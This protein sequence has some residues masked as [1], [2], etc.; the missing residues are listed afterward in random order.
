M[1][2]SRFA[3]RFCLAKPV[4]LPVCLFAIAWALLTC[5]SSAKAADD[6]FQMWVPVQIVHPFGEEWAASMQAEVRLKD[7]ISE[8][9]E[10]VLK[11][12]LHY[13]FEESWVFSAGYKFI[14][15]H[16]ESN[17]H[18]PWQE[19]GLSKTFDDLV[20]GYQVRIEERLIEDIDGVIP[21][22]RLLAHFSH[23]IGDSP[24]YL[25]GFGAVRFNLDD[26]GEG[27]VSGF[28]QSRVSV[29][30]GHHIGDRVQFEVGYLWRYEEERTGEDQS[31]H[32]IHFQLI[33][34]TKRKRIKKPHPR[35]RYR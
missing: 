32:V 35:D 33:L 10:L 20:T 27:P 16:E 18:D 29:A 8:F 24:H 14:D 7:D 3:P 15:K 19:I 11:P 21:R 25:T 6:D 13:H 22:L 9:S 5:V 23:P 31:D 2:E 26:K 28:E 12:A 30:L 4:R 17:E 1:K 34:N